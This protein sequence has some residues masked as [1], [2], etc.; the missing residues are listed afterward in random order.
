MRKSLLIQ[1]ILL[2]AIIANSQTYQH[3]QYEQALIDDNIRSLAVDED[4]NVWIGTFNGITKFDGDNFTSWTIDNGLGGNLIYDIHIHSSGTV[5][6]A[7][8]G[9]LSFYDGAFWGNFAIGDGLPS[10]TIWCVTEDLDGRIWIGTSDAGVAYFDGAFWQ[11]YSTSQGLVTNAIRT[12]LAD[13]SGNMW[14]ASG[15]GLSFFNGNEFKTF[16]T[17]NGLPGL[18][19][20]DIIQ[21]DNGNIAVA[22][23]GG[24]G[25]Y[26]YSNWQTITASNGLPASNVLSLRED[27]EN[28][29]IM[30]T[31]IGVVKYDWTDFSVI[32]KS[33]GLTDNIVTKIELTNEGNNKL[34][35]SSPFDGVTEYDND[36]TFNIYRKHRN[37]INDNVN[38]V[39]VD[40]DNIVWIGTEEGLNRVENNH[41][42]SYSTTTGLVANNITIIYKDSNQNVWI[43]TNDG[44]SRLN[45]TVITNFSTDNGLS[46]NTIT[47]ITSDPTGLVYVST[48]NGVTVFEEGIII[49]IIDTDDGLLDNLVTNVHYENGRLWFLQNEHI[50]YFDGVSFIDVTDD[51]CLLDQTFS[52][53]ACLNCEGQQ[54]FGTDHSLRMFDNGNVSTNCWEHPYPGTATIISIVDTPNGLLCSFD[55]GEVQLFDGTNWIIQTMSYPVSFIA[56]QGDSYFWYAYQEHGVEKECLHCTES[57][58]YIA[59]SPDCHGS[60]NASLS[61]NSPIGTYMYSIDNGVTWN[62]GTSFNNLSGGYKHI[63][64]KNASD[65]IVLDE[66]IFIDFYDHITESHITISQIDCF[67]NNNGSV[68]LF[69]DFS[70]SHIWENSNT[71]IYERNNLGAGNYSVTISDNA[72][73]QKILTN[74]IIEPSV[75]SVDEDFNHVSCFGDQN[76]YIILSISGGTLPYNT[77]WNTGHISPNFPNLNGG[78]YSYTVTD[79]N[80]CMLQNS[81]VINE[82]TVLE[83]S[84]EIEDVFCYGGTNGSITI[85]VEG[86]MIPHQIN[87]SPNTYVDLDNNIVNA[88]AGN[89]NLTVTD[90]N[91]CEIIDIITINQP[92]VFAISGEDIINVYCYGDETGQIEINVVGGFGDYDFLWIKDGSPGIFSESQNIY[93]LSA[94]TYYVT[95][96]DENLCETESFYLITESPELTVELT[97]TPISCAG[98]DDGE[99]LASASG[100]TGNYIS[101]LWMD[102][103]NNPISGSYMPHIT[104]LGE[105]FYKVRVTDTYYC[106][107]MDST[108][109][110]QAQP[111]EY[112]ITATPM[113]CNGLDDGMIEVLVNGGAGAGFTFAWEGGVAG[114]INVALNLGEGNYTV[115]VTDPNECANILSANVNQPPMESIGVFPEVEYVCYGNSLVLNPGSFVTYNWSTGA[116][117]PTITVENPGVY[118]VNVRAIDGCRLTDTVEVIVS[119]VYQN[120]NLNLASVTESGNIKLFWEKTSGHGTELYKIF[121]DSGNG[122]QHIA[123]KLFNEPAIYEDANVDPENNYY[124]YMISVVDSCGNESNM[125][126]VHRTMLLEANHNQYGACFLNWSSYEGFFVVYYFIMSG[127]SP[128]NIQVTDSTLYYNNNYAQMNPNPGGTYY[129]LKVRRIDGVHPGDGNYYNSAYS[130]IVF[131]DN[132]TGVVNSA[133]T[134]VQLYPNPFIS[135]L[136]LEFYLQIPS[137]V[138]ASVVDM[139]GREIEVFESENL[140]AG[141]H[142]LNFNLNLSPGLY[143]LRLKVNDEIHSYRIVSE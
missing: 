114:N 30:A 29:L 140:E 19:I 80:N 136:N 131:C 121:K 52:K 74:A 71:V 20:N 84:Y 15:N 135:Y 112:Q 47:G 77:I 97:V 141:N 56:N 95:V 50:Q 41:W 91:M 66:V 143:V 98:Y 124:R 37:L 45:G 105:G 28:N 104:G 86:G 44:L 127:S 54:Y 128:D 7:T 24:I 76:A 109:L 82:P 110:T 2:V 1:F 12:I 118:I 122:F 113:S 87:W 42:R 55:N 3:F 49:Q 116:T 93:D 99:I 43:G 13:R 111:N 25:I 130:N 106:V 119:V 78:T 94:G 120:E 129:R 32:N 10:N 88:P 138:S 90:A 75:L 61:I 117:T 51:G 108:V 79:A 18:I 57:L 133:I 73:C 81:I 9:G 64:V 92:Q 125:S 123:S 22:T 70:G 63:L 137:Y 21:L 14:F 67:G 103:N 33:D 132:L 8:S 126:E 36:N 96:T 23:N 83:L 16:N 58:D 53:A 134:T 89:Y 38:Y 60:K 35:C 102:E 142:D 48:L 4:D 59:V 39:Y 27:Y 40:D 85:D 5:Y 34:W 17:S 26:N 107:V 115:T 101:Y 46:D 72:S 69:Y 68:V 11:Q 65:L 6:C 62:A 31:A 139:L 100:G